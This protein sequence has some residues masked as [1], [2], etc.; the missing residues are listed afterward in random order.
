MEI[1]P[2]QEIL[3]S[4]RTFFCQNTLETALFESEQTSL[5]QLITRISQGKQ[6]RPIQCGDQHGLAQILGHPKLLK[7]LN[8]PH[9]CQNW[10]FLEIQNFGQSI[11]G[12]HTVLL[13]LTTMN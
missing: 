11:L 2:Q 6:A 5:L 12:H 13:L 9:I 1:T 8:A 10:T 7:N 3:C 4:D